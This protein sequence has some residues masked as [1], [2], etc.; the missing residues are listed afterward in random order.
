MPTLE[1]IAEMMRKYTENNP[2]GANI[3]WNNV[4]GIKRPYKNNR[5]S[6]KRTNNRCTAEQLKLLA[7]IIV[8]TGGQFFTIKE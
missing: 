5:T 1:D 8:M 6:S 4:A 7:D 3:N 2:G